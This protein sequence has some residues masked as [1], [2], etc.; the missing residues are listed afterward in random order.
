ITGVGP[1]GGP[2]RGE[3]R[4]SALLVAGAGAA[5]G[6]AGG[7]LLAIRRRGRRPIPRRRP[8]S[9]QAISPAGAM[10]KAAELMALPQVQRRDEAITFAQTHVTSVE[11]LLKGE[12]Y[13]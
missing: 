12:L 2:I 9:T 11:L 5:A 8:T 1:S 7:A 10:A 3:R 6:A 13:F 4:R